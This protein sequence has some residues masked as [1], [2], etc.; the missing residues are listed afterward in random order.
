MD[1]RKK[2][3]EKLEEKSKVEKI[4]F[5]IV[6]TAILVF[7]IYLSAYIDQVLSS[8]F[9]NFSNITWIESLF[10][11]LKNKNQVT[12]FLLFELI[13]LSV[14]VFLFFSD[15]KGYQSKLV[16]ITPEILIPE[17][18]GQGQFG[19]ARFAKEEEIEKE[20]EVNI[21]NSND[22]IIKKLLKGGEA[23]QAII[24]DMK[25]ETEGGEED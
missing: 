2:I 4:F 18:S 16:E 9:K 1:I 15:L 14:I 20:F 13:G 8:K 11:L 24:K 19:T 23:D 25:I 22:E 7:S 21:L 6:S 12:I 3:K 10:G 5:S 17:S